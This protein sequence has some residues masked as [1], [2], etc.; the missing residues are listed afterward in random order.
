M[1][2]MQLGIAGVMFTFVVDRQARVIRRIMATPISRRNYMAAHVLERLIL[3]V[4]QVLILLAVAVFASRSR[5]SQPPARCCSCR[6][7]AASCSC[8]LASRSPAS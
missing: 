8:A 2:I 7:S 5:S 4:L 3:A 6:C 1:T